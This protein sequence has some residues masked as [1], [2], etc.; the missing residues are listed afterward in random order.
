MRVHPAPKKRSITFRYDANASFS[1]AVE[2]LGRQKKLRRLPHIFSKVLELPFHADADVSIA[3]DSDCFRFVAAVAGWSGGVRARAIQ[4][5]PGVMKVVIR[6]SEVGSGDD[7]G[8]GDDLSVEDLELDRW[9]FRL[10]PETRP[11]RATA[12]YSDGELIVT[13]P[14]CLDPD[15]IEEDGEEDGLGGDLINSGINQLVLV[16]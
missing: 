3:E 4:I 8:S 7:A 6:D 13:V 1:A 9:R 14:K 16:Q 11:A 5:Y 10:P 15:D 2:I 12:E